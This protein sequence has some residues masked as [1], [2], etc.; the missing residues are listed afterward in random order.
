GA[1]SLGA[2]VEYLRSL[3]PPWVVKTDGLAA[4]KGVLVTSS[5]EAAMAD[6][7]AKLSGASFGDAGRTV[8]IEEGLVGQEISL[9]ALCD[10]RRAVPLGVA[11]DF[12]RVGEGDSGPNTGGMGAFSPVLGMGPAEAS[13]L[14]AQMVQPVVDALRESGIDYRGIIYAGLMLTP[15]GP[16]M[17]EINV[18]LGDPE[19]QVL[20][21]R[22]EGDVAAVMSAAAAG[23]LD[24]S[25]PPVLSADSAVCVVLAAEGYPG[26][27]RSGDPISGIDEVGAAEGVCVFAGGVAEGPAGGLVTSGGRVLGVTGMGPTLEEARERAYRGAGLL[28]WDGMTFRG[29]IAAPAVVPVAPGE[30]EVLG[31]PLGNASGGSGAEGSPSG[32]SGA[33]WSA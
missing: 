21:P 20:M 33:E 10:G 18:R 26:A 23:D 2:A 29:D 15:D 31:E 7:E 13:A 19:A 30:W 8:V 4:G 14:T 28:R 1:A 11:R 17:I 16:K 6:V 9:M 5:L 22:W 3:P 25:A 27:V 24:G 12:K 32:G